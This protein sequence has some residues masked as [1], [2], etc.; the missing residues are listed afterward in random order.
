MSNSAKGLAVLT[1]STQAG[2]FSSN[3]KTALQVS[4]SSD[5][6]DALF[7]WGHRLGIKC[8]ADLHDDSQAAIFRSDGTPPVIEI[9]GVISR[10][11]H[12]QLTPGSY[13][14][15]IFGVPITPPVVP[16][17]IYNSGPNIF[18]CVESDYDEGDWHWKK[19]ALQNI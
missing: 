9:D 2:W 13:R 4:S 5:T 18:V 7:V 11:T 17:G 12:I 15:P 14:Q 3:Q 6:S 8:I 1:D 16:G 19:V 10:H